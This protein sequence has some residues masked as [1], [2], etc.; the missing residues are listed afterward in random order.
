MILTK[1]I[2][3]SQ[4]AAYLGIMS[5]FFGLAAIV[6]PFIGAAILQ[7]TT[8]RW[9]FGINLPLGAVTVVLCFLFVHTPLDPSVQ[10][11]SI[12]EKSLQL[13][14]PGT[15][16]MVGSLISLLIAL[17][18]GGA[19]YPCKCDLHKMIVYFLLVLEV[20]K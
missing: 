14:M 15:V 16:C 5:A 2:P 12:I 18:W 3:L 1:I 9:C 7:S 4:R 6:G 13:D 8:W 11:L 19:T 17:Q 20:H 10:N